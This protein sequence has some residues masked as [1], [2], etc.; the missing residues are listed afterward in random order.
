MPALT[1]SRTCTVTRAL[2]T[3]ASSA[4][5]YDVIVLGTGAFGSAAAYHLASQGARVFAVDSYRPGHPWGS[6]HGQTRIIRLAYFE[7]QEYFQL[8]HRSYD[9]FL[10]LQQRVGEVSVFGVADA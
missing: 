2:A 1:A 4:K 7:G 5:A 10:D 9:L 6:S 3:S 8:I